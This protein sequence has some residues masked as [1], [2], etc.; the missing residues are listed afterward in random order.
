MTSRIVLNNRNTHSFVE[1]FL[2]LNMIKM[3]IINIYMKEYSLQSSGKNIC[4]LLV[5]FWRFESIFTVHTLQ[6]TTAFKMN[7]SS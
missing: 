3:L 6:A 5:Y 4:Y 2:T 1:C 7:S